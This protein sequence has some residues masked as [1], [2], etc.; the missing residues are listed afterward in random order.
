M[1]NTIL[2]F[3]LFCFFKNGV[4]QDKLAI[5]KVPNESIYIHYNANYFLS[6]EKL[7]YSVYC[8][9]QNSKK[10]SNLSKIAYVELIDSNQENYFKHKIKLENGVGQGDFFIPVGLKTGTYKIIGY[11]NWIKNLGIKAFFYE[12]IFIINPYENNGDFIKDNTTHTIDLQGISNTNSLISINT[13]KKKYFKREAIKFTVNALKDS[14]SYGNYSISIR[15]K[16]SL[17]ISYGRNLLSSKI[18]R[19]NKE[20][21]VK[22]LTYTPEFRGEIIEGVV[23]DINSGAPVSNCSVSFTIP[24][25]NYIFKIVKTN[26]NGKFFIPIYENYNK[27]EAIIKI[28][29]SKKNNYKVTIKEDLPIVFNDLD[30]KKF[31][32]SKSHL[33]ELITKSKDIQIENA[34][35]FLK[36]DSLISSQ[37]PKRFFGFS[38]EKTI[39]YVLD[40]YTRFKTLKETLTEIVVGAYHYKRKGNYYLGI[41]G[42][43]FLVEENHPL[44][45][46]DGVRILDVNQIINY[47]TRKVNKITIKKE[48]YSYGTELFNGIIDIETYNGDYKAIRN[49]KNSKTISL[50]NPLQLKKYY[51]PNYAASKSERIP[52]FRYQ[53]FWKPN[54]KLNQTSKELEFYTS[55]KTGVFEMILEGFTN[56]GNP[57]SIKKEFTVE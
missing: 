33:Q 51:Q 42:V 50:F 4:S 24:D 53:L 20:L 35:N 38:D 22:E 14:L 18:L 12:D 26:S 37:P 16:D 39:T 43:N 57:I 27:S 28:T 2:L 55:D 30:F 7:Y 56:L 40:D 52:D 3:L 11:T 31:T 29:D 25:K 36:Q 46:I 1:K 47:N 17:N 13:D 21:A 54:I 9:N 44:I 23:T 19:N 15:K 49:S 32:I 10:L 6:G 5:E 34:Y 45:L 41:L 48:N 8:I